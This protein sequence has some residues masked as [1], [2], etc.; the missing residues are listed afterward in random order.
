MNIHLINIRTYLMQ[1]ILVKNLSDCIQ[2]KLLTVVG[3]DNKSSIYISIDDA[4][5]PSLSNN[6]LARPIKPDLCNN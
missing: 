6:C 4:I 1:K 2:Q 3:S 5:Y